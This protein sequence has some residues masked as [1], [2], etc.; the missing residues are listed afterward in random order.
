MYSSA[1]QMMHAPTITAVAITRL[2]VNLNAA[3][4]TMAGKN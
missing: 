1:E 4:K 3:K 2:L